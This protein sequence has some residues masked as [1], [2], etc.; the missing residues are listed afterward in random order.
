MSHA[1]SYERTKSRVSATG[2][3]EIILFQCGPMYA[4]PM[5]ALKL[6]EISYIHASLCIW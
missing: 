3:D 6:K 1:A 5:K 4:L 2:R